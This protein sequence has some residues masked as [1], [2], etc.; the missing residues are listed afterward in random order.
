MK[1]RIVSMSALQNIH[2]KHRI[3]VGLYKKKLNKKIDG[4][5]AIAAS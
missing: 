2:S 4:E 5:Y 1:T 3:Y